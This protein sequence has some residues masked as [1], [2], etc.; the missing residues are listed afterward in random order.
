MI[1][2]LVA[3]QGEVVNDV[4]PHVRGNDQPIP[5]NL[6]ESVRRYLGATDD[7]PTWM[8]AARTQEF[9]ADDRVLVASMLPFGA[10]VNCYTQPQ[11]FR[12]RKASPPTATEPR[13]VPIH[14][15]VARNT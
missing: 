15:P 11:L 5:E 7:P 14:V 9:F 12:R 13:P 10:R 3:N 2:E 6:P 8:D 1:A 4:L